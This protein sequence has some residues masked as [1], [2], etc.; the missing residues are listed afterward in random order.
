MSAVSWN[1]A[2]KKISKHLSCTTFLHGIDKDLTSGFR[3]VPTNTLQKR[4]SIFESIIKKY[5]TIPPKD[6]IEHIPARPSYF[7]NFLMWGLCFIFLNERNGIVIYF[8]TSD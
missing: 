3:I 1:D 5:I 8:E 6:V 7:G 2:Y 4:I